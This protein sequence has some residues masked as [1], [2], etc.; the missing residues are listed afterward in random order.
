MLLRKAL[1]IRFIVLGGP[2]FAF[3]P[4]LWDPDPP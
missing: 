3:W 1:N 4:D 2:G